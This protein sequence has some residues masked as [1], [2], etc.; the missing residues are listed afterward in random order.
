MSGTENRLQRRRGPA[1]SGV[2]STYVLRVG[3]CI[4]SSVF[5]YFWES[6]GCCGGATGEKSVIDADVLNRYI[7]SGELCAPCYW[8]QD[9]FCC[10]EQTRAWLKRGF[11]AGFIIS[12][13][14]DGEVPARIARSWGATVVRGSAKAS[15]ALAMRDIHQAMKNGVSIVTA[16]DGPL[17]PKYYFKP[18]VVLMARIGSAPM[19]PIACAADRAWYL[20]RWDDFMLPKP[21]ARVVISVGEPQL[22]PRDRSVDELEQHRLWDGKGDQCSQAAVRSSIDNGRAR[23]R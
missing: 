23:R 12:A 2:Q 20:K 13:S 21:F 6:A 18:G 22:M 4:I 10:L 7:R 8:H 5:R 17:G 11:K 9:S 16:A 15:N 3:V 1:Q 14:V 19:I